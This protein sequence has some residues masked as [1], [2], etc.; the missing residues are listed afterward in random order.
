MLDTSLCLPLAADRQYH[1]LYHQ[2]RPVL[3]FAQ[4][5]TNRIFPVFSKYQFS[6][7]SE[8]VAIEGPCMSLDDL[9]QGLLGH[10][11]NGIQSDD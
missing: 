1:L 11:P 4:V 7:V 8:W 10:N 6:E 5:S 2:I 9:C 3:S